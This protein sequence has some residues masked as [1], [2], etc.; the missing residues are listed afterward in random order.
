VVGIKETYIVEG[1]LIGVGPRDALSFASADIIL[2]VVAVAAATLL[3]S[4]QF[5]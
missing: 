5:A 4:P 2:S 1:L 3:R